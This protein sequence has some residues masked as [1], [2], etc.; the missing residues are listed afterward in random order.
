MKK[1]PTFIRRLRRRQN[2]LQ[3]YRKPRAF[4]A[5]IPLLGTSAPK[6]GS[7]PPPTHAEKIREMTWKDRREQDFHSG[8]YNLK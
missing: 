1:A 4:G 2:V 7:T 6:K 8:V 5:R 3:N